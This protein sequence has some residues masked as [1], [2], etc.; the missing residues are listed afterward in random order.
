[1]EVRK[2]VF[3]ILVIAS[4]LILVGV[5]SAVDFSEVN[6]F[7]NL[8]DNL[9]V[10]LTTDGST[11]LLSAYISCEGGENVIHFEYLIEK[12][13]V[14]IFIPLIKE[15]V[16]DLKGICKIK[17]NFNDEE[18]YSNDFELSQQIDISLSFPEGIEQEFNPG[19]SIQINGEAKRLNGANVNGLAEFSLIAVS[20][21]EIIDEATDEETEET[22]EEETSEDE[23]TE[24]TDEEETE[25]ESIEGVL[26]TFSVDIIEGAFSGTLI[27]PS[28]LSPGTYKIDVYAYEMDSNAEITNEG[29]YSREIIIK[30]KPASIEIILNP[31]SIKAGDSF[32]LIGKVYDQI[33]REM[34][35]VPI[36]LKIVDSNNTIIDTSTIH[37]GEPETIS[38]ESNALKGL[39]TVLLSA[40]S[41]GNSRALEVLENVEADFRVEN[42]SLIVKNVGNAYYDKTVTIKIGDES[43]VKNISLDIGE[44]K[45]Y[46]LKAPSGTYDIEI[47]DANK[48]ITA[49]GVAL[50]GRA[51]SV[52]GE[53]EGI[54][55]LMRGFS[56]LWIFV[57]IM[58][59]AGT[60][61][62]IKK[63]GNKGSGFSYKN[64]PLIS[65]IKTP[66]FLKKI[67]LPNIFIHKKREKT[68]TIKKEVKLPETLA[69][70]EEILVMGEKGKGKI[71]ESSLVIKGQKQESGILALKIK[72]LP[73]LKTNAINEIN[74]ISEKI[75]ESHGS[76]Y[77]T[78]GYLIGLFVPSIT[79]TFKNE[80]PIIKLSKE[81][82]KDL[83]NY[84]RKF[85]DKIDFGIG[86][87]SG[88][89][90]ARDETGRLLFT[91]LGNTLNHAKRIADIAEKEALLSEI[92]HKRV[93]PEIKSEKKRGVKHMN[94]YN[95]GQIVERGRHNEFISEFLKRQDKIKK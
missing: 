9:E 62:F 43:I 2:G 29:T 89:I 90:I 10:T 56:I 88:E 36:D 75:I 27:L 19:D 25:E 21:D 4:I 78:E 95:V 39:W 74:K 77:K 71:A 48:V 24:E 66:S 59:C 41:A 23:E 22:D 28:D 87:N 47:S 58:L 84:N 30:Q 8:G 82:I 42:K 64:I 32:E 73:E 20:V 93:I 35:N 52:R 61:V 63:I 60:F 13:T 18:S 57:F 65:K 40:E 14:D 33:M 15:I 91:S 1:M 86:V 6:S 26:E 70:K 16:G 5:V 69:P 76:V 94:V 92:V 31:E 44:E 54:G 45:S 55:G 51:V 67:K 38:L 46:E 80:K 17:V 37:S 50:T 53:D 34:S 49:S 11:G 79:K 72:N 81:L 68:R 83:E 3:G 85:T 12:N 7:Y